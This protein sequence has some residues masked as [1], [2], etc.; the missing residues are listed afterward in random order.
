MSGLNSRDEAP[1]TRTGLETEVFLTSNPKRGEVEPGPSLGLGG[2]PAYSESSH[3]G[4]AHI[5][6][7]TATWGL[8]EGLHERK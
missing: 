8:L 2:Q 1:K 3:G 4:W 5:W 7:C 6:V